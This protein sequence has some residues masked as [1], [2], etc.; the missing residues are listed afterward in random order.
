MDQAIVD[1]MSP[2]EYLEYLQDEIYSGQLPSFAT[3]VGDVLTANLIASLPQEHRR[4][5]ERIAIGVL[6]SRE[7]TAWV[8]GGRVI[9]FSF[10]LMSFLLAL[11][12]VLMSRVQMPGLEPTMDIEPAARLARSI[13]ESFFGG[14][15]LPIVRTSPTQL[16][17]ASALSNLQVTYAVGHELGHVLSG[18]FNRIGKRPIRPAEYQRMEHEADIRGG[19]M[20]LDSFK[21][22]QGALFGAGD[23]VLA[24][25]GVDVFFTYLGFMNDLRDLPVRPDRDS[26]PTP[27]TRR[28][29]L[30]ERF[31]QDMPEQAKALAT[32]AE[33]IFK[34]FAHILQPNEESNASQAAAETEAQIA[35]TPKKTGSTRTGNKVKQADGRKRKPASN[36]D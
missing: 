25:A 9:A 5:L 22:G 32:Q 10:G 7:I 36:D 12:K 16:L 23:T 17:V 34:A 24:Q 26:H 6:P 8:E 19:E 27:E 31:W 33:T 14:E 28:D 20:A 1:S 11:N 4:E 30:R 21:R 15:K 3:D 13:I 18:H 29:K 35:A 2:Q